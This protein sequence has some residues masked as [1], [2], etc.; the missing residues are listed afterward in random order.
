MENIDD[1]ELL[2]VN[3]LDGEVNQE[4]T[5]EMAMQSEQCTAELTAGESQSVE[6][7]ASTPTSVTRQLSDFLLTQIMTNIDQDKFVEKT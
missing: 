7:Q 4:E 2:L 6:R 5:E 1:D 3:N